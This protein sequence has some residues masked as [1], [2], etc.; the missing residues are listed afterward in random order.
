MILLMMDPYSSVWYGEGVEYLYEDED[1][2]DD[3]MQYSPKNSIASA[4]R[5]ATHYSRT[6]KAR[7]QR[8][9]LKP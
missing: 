8:V 3:K 7:Y 2:E 4:D 5:V 6:Q 9:Y 1:E